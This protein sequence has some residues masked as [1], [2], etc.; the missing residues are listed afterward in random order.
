ML[1]LQLISPATFGSTTV[2]TK[3]SIALKE[4]EEKKHSNDAL[5]NCGYYRAVNQRC[6]LHSAS[7]LIPCGKPLWTAHKHS[8]AKETVQTKKMLRYKWCQH[9]TFS[10]DSSTRCLKLSHI[11]VFHLSQISCTIYAPVLRPRGTVTAHRVQSQLVGLFWGVAMSGP[12]SE[13][14]GALPVSELSCWEAWNWVLRW[15]AMAPASEVMPTGSYYCHCGCFKPFSLLLVSS[16]LL[17]TCFLL[18][19]LFSSPSAGAPQPQGCAAQRLSTIDVVLSENA[20]PK[21]NNQQMLQHSFNTGSQRS[22]HTVGT[23]AG[24]LKPPADSR[25]IFKALEKIVND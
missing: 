2:I 7:K 4:E 5:I 13:A 9:D 8:H 10:T 16:S 18:S 3:T 24:A 20:V 19:W 23:Q 12:L 11:S 21:D 14:L 6:S 15:T 22:A 17:Q 1:N 25:W